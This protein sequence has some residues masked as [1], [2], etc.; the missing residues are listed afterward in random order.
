MTTNAKWFERPAFH[1]GPSRF[2]SVRRLQQTGVVVLIDYLRG[3]CVFI[4]AQGPDLWFRCDNGFEFPV[5][6]VEL[7]GALVLAEER[8]AVLM[9]WIYRH[10]KLV[11]SSR[12]Q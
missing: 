6:F 2:K 12:E 3:N 9:K 11:E 8:G 10:R 5:P 4:K 7:G 1:A